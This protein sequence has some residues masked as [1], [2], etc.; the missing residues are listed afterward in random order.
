MSTGAIVGIGAGV[1]VIGGV[2]FL[3]VHKQNAAAVAVANA[4]AVAA[5]RAASQAKGGAGDL[6]D[7][8][9]RLGGRLL[10]MGAEYLTKGAAGFAASQAQNSQVAV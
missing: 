5:S 10:G 1:V 9:A 3:L 7:A 8:L 2:V 6:G 4:E